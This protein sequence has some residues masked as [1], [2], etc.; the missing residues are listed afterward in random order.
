[1]QQARSN[2][3][4]WRGAALVAV[5]YAYFL[6]FA[7][8]A[9]L[10]RLAELGIGGAGV[11]MA[12]AAMALGGILL[13]LLAPRVRFKSCAT[14]RL[15]VAFTGCAAAAFLAIMPLGAAGN[16]AEAFLAGAA[17]GLLTV[18]LTTHLRRFTGEV[19]PV[20]M[21]GAGTGAGYFACNIPQLFTAP[22]AT[23][24]VVAGLLCLAGIGIT[25]I[26]GETPVE[27]QQPGQR[28]SASIP[29]A[30]IS[31]TALVWLDSAAFFIIQNT[32]S[33][34]AATWQGASRLWSIGT[35]HLCAA[36]FAAWLLLRRGL[37]AV[38]VAAFLTLG[39]ACLL[40]RDA[41]RAHLASVLYPVGVSLYSVALVAFPSLIAAAASAAE[42]GRI[43]GWVYAIAGWAGSA[44]GVGMGQNLGRIPPAFVVVAGAAILVFPL[45]RLLRQSIREAAAV[46]AALLVALFGFQLLRPHQTL[47]SE[48]AVERG[49][50]VYISEGCIHCHSQYVRP[51]SRDALMWGPAAS[52]EE[53]RRQHPPLIGNRRQGPD[54]SQVGARRSPLWLKAHFFNPPE[55]S[56]ASIMPAYGFLFGD[57]R[58]DDLVAYLASLRSPGQEAQIELERQ[59]HPSTEAQA[60][61]SIRD[62]ELVYQR[63]C[64]TCHD[65]NGRTRR[66]WLTAFR[67]PPTSLAKGPF[68]DLAPANSPQQRQLRLE[69]IAKFGIPG[70]DM[71]G[72]EYLSDHEIASLGLW[73]RQIALQS[74]PGS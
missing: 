19:Q 66:A 61:A 7:Q 38:F 51:N 5:T 22:A 31:F 52:M 69:Q 33:L 14:T 60:Q 49:R 16:A 50:M 34:Q 54:L 72:H 18:T 11:K 73:L 28:P 55:V 25:F 58:G 40:L 64:A 29:L 70:T 8:F 47:T 56:G 57:G 37:T 12:M 36:L 13:S 48:T 4:G 41:N 3:R 24:C 2:A 44:M 20:L 23:Q 6:I 59:W 43:A 21:V 35:L 42:R 9:Y 15:R 71:P 46:F 1:M 30:V 17:L 32:P 53:L 67:R 10:R 62:G 26:R 68:L 65:A 74:N 63:D 27:V 45:I 39:S